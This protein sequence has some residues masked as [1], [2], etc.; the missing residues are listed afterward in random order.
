M[1]ALSCLIH[2]RLLGLKYSQ[3]TLQLLQSCAPFL[4]GHKQASCPLK[5]SCEVA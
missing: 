3:A 5:L 2:T 1:L 4:L